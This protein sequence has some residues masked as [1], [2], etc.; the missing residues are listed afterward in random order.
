MRSRRSNRHA[1]MAATEFGRAHGTPMMLGE[2]DGLKG[3]ASRAGA[4]V[5]AL[6]PAALAQRSA[7]MPFRAKWVHRL[8]VTFLMGRKSV[9]S[10]GD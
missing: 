8:G 6:D 7:V 10:N 3:R 5:A 4:P 1:G 2:D 9:F